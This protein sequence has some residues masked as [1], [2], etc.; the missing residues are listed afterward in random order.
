M[1][2]VPSEP[3]WGRQHARRLRELYRS[4]GWPCQDVVEIELLAG[5]MLE[6]VADAFGR[7]T[8]RVTDR[9]LALAAGQ[10]ARNR[11]ALSAHEALVRRVSA[12]QVAAGRV[13]WCG[14]ALRARLP[15]GEPLPPGVDAAPADLLGEPASP[16]APAALWGM[17][18]PDVFS[19]RNTTVPT[20]VEPL[21]HEIKVQRSDLLADLRRPAKRGAYLD[22]GACWYVLGSDARGRC[23]ADPSEVPAECGVLVEEGGRLRA[24]RNAPAPARADLPFA[25]WMALARASPDTPGEV[26]LQALI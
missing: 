19:I 11:A 12:L 22:L 24:A 16:P 3:V 8:V 21:V 10:A 17:V 7:E 23:I 6:R 15:A 1:T 2:L 18:R 25:V 26:M 4:A 13:A 5:G 20:Y 9:G 14:L